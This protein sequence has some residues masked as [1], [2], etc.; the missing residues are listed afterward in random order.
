MFASLKKNI[1]LIYLKKVMC[2]TNNYILVLKF[3]FYLRVYSWEKLVAPPEN[4]TMPLIGEGLVQGGR[5][6]NDDDDDDDD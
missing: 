6:A 2:K 3:A 5:G 4:V 1:H